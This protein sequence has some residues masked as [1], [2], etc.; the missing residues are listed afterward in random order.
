MIKNKTQN[1][2][3]TAHTEYFAN[4]WSRASG[5]MFRKVKAGVG[6]LFLFDK[7]TYAAI[8]MLFVFEPIDVLWLDR[9]GRVIDMALHVKP[10]TLH[11][12]P[13]GYATFM[14]EMAAGTIVLSLTQIGDE[15]EF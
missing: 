6:Y 3:V 4:S 13:N 8:H 2:T 15:I 14:I 11:A 7:P 1:T 5:L 9:D 10:W 12:A